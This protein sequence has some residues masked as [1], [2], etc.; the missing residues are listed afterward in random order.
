MS[1]GKPLAAAS[2]EAASGDIGYNFDLNE[3][4]RELQQLARK[5]AREEILPKAAEYDKSGAFP[6]DI[7]K[8]AHSLGILNGFVPEKFGGPGLSTL[9]NCM[10]GEEFAYGCTGILTAITGSGLAAAPVLIGGS[11]AQIKNMWE[12]SLKNLLSHLTA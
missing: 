10:I 8:K 1:T 7:L 9:E 2:T 5:F 4:Q 3:T 6:W 11:D 12:D